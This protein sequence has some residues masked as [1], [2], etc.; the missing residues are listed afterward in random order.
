ME[1][2]EELIDDGDSTTCHLSSGVDL[3]SPAE[4][5]IR[6]CFPL[7]LEEELQA[8]IAG[9]GGGEVVLEAVGEGPV[10]VVSGQGR[11]QPEQ[12][13]QALVPRM[14]ERMRPGD[15]K[16]LFVRN[17]RKATDSV[18]CKGACAVRAA[19]IGL[20]EDSQLEDVDVLGEGGFGTVSAVRH[21]VLPGE[22]ALKTLR[23]VRTNLRD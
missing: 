8:R 3:L 17:L 21:A 1:L 15:L 2:E 9:R 10:E 13:A 6:T 14:C 23:E 22:F 11:E 12:G 19:K 4:N 5:S 18:S 16:A 20:L 7:E